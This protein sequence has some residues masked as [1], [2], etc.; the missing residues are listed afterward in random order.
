MSV[1]CAFC[2]AVASNGLELRHYF[3][4]GIRRWREENAAAGRSFEEIAAHVAVVTAALAW[5]DA[6]LRYKAALR[7]ERS[8]EWGDEWR[9]ASVAM[10]PAEDA[11]V[12]ALEPFA[13]EKRM[14]GRCLNSASFEGRTLTDLELMQLAAARKSFDEAL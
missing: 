4:C 8:D 1:R 3:H 5:R 14:V 10:T 12:A 2:G 11:L 7:A 6:R 9:A 13:P